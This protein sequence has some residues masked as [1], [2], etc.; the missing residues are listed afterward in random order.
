MLSWCLHIK[1]ITQLGLRPVM[2]P[3]VQRLIYPCY[4]ATWPSSKS[5]RSFINR[6][7]DD[8]AQ[9]RWSGKW[10]Q[11]LNYF[12]IASSSLHFPCHA[13][14]CCHLITKY[15][16][17]TIAFP[18]IHLLRVNRQLI[19]SWIFINLEEVSFSLIKES[20]FVALLFHLTTVCRTRNAEQCKTNKNLPLALLHAEV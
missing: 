5:R 9:L 8:N 20:H 15:Q 1:L 10:K 4:A 19:I 7:W 17:L 6:R 11:V 16:G 13:D 18:T 3:R 2:I 12:A 14:T